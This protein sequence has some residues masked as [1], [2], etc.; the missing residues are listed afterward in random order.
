MP[1]VN[2][3]RSPVG[4]SGYAY[5][6]HWVGL[7]GYKDGTVEQTGVDAYCDASGDAT[8]DA[9]Y[10]MYPD[11]SV[12]YAGVSPG[13]AITASVYWNGSAYSLSLSDLTTGGHFSVSKRCPSG[14]ACKN[15]SAEVISEDPGGAVADGYNLAD[16]AAAHYD[17]AAVTSRS[18]ARGTLGKSRQWSSSVISMTDPAGKIMARPS[19]LSGGQAFA[20]SWDR[21]R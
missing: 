17:S 3:S 10:E 9:W 18:G 14:S 4:S 7:D 13:D 6:G 15:S 20:I 21:S 8:Y 12:V 1:A 19:A 5:V 16:F 2:C 11:N